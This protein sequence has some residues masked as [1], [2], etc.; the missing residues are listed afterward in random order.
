MT[1]CGQ[2]ADHLY[3][4]PASESSTELR[5]FPGD[6]NISEIIQRVGGVRGQVSV[7]TNSTDPGQEADDKEGQQAEESTAAKQRASVSG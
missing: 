5:S 3:E 2:R 6:I 7:S 1:L 4:S